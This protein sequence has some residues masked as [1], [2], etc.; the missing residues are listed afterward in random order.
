MSDTPWYN[1]LSVERYSAKYNNAG[2]LIA[3]YEDASLD[4]REG[5]GK[6]F[7]W[8]AMI[9]K[10]TGTTR[11]CDGDRA[12]DLVA[13]LLLSTEVDGDYVRVTAMVEEPKYSGKYC[14]EVWMQFRPED[15][16]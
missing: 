6:C 7:I 3:K 9:D 10:D 8:I 13:G 11:D 5:E 2:K 1:G 12:K 4:T 14:Q 16:A 15:K